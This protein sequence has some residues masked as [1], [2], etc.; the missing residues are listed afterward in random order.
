M[1]VTRLVM[2]SYSIIRKRL[3][4]YE[5]CTYSED[6]QIDREPHEV[7]R[8]LGQVGEEGDHLQ[9][10]GAQIAAPR[11]AL[12]DAQQVTAV[13]DVCVQPVG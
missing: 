11:L 3:L 10:A 5:L 6:E 12:R 9:P 13:R 7:V 4:T 2:T 8:G 1:D